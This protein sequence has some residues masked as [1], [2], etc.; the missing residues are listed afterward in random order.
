MSDEDQTRTDEQAQLEE[1]LE[2]TPQVSP[3]AE[4][5]AAQAK[6]KADDARHREAL[7]A[8]QANAPEP[9]PDLEAELARRDAIREEMLA[10]Q[11]RIDDAQAMIDAERAFMEAKAAEL[12]PSARASDRP[13]DAIRGY[14][15]GQAAER[16][17][18]PMNQ[19]R[20][21]GL[22]EAAGKSPIDAAFHHAR[23]RGTKRPTRSLAA[24][25][26]ET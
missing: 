20:L 10:A 24:T 18:R 11:G 26:S 25:E 6:K 1:A 4:E 13:V 21:K 3:A 14:L 2:A 17:N 22:L 15:R 5:T 12:Y 23:A 7:A 9:D 8:A 16:K 19:A